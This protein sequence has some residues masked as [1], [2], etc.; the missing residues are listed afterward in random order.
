MEISMGKTSIRV[1]K[2]IKDIAGDGVKLFILRG[3]QAARSLRWT[4]IKAPNH[5]P[6]ASMDGH[7]A[8]RLMD[9]LWD[10]GVR[11]TSDAG[12][13]AMPAVQHHLQ[14]MRAI[15]AATLKLSL[16]AMPPPPTQKTFVQIGAATWQ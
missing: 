14:D 2:D 7:A 1:A 9:D 6:L 8:Q 10:C 11:P 4:K 16:P 13:R 12:T 15:V 3:D 5:D